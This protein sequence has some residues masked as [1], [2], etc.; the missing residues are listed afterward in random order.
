MSD[1]FRLAQPAPV[2]P[3]RP[4]IA[5]GISDFARIRREGKYYVDKTAQIAAL[6]EDDP[7]PLLLTRP[8]RFGKTL[9][10]DTLRRFLELDYKNP[11][12]AALPRQLFAGLRIME[13]PVLQSCRERCMAQYPVIAVTFAAVK[14]DSW[15]E[16]LQRMC[17]ALWEELSRHTAN[18]DFSVLP[19]H[20]QLR[21]QHHTALLIGNDRQLQ[22]EIIPDILSALAGW[23]HQVHG[24]PAYI[25]ID[26]YDTPLAKAWSA[27]LTSSRDQGR[28]G[29]YQRMAE[30]MRGILLPLLKPSP[31]AQDSIAGCIL[32]GCTR[33]SRESLFS[34]TNNL[35]VLGMD[36]LP[37]ADLM[38]FTEDEVGEML[39]CFSLEG[40]LAEARD[41]YD[42]Y[43]FAGV[44]IYNPWSIAHY[45]QDICRNPSHHPGNFW[46]AAGRND[47]LTAC[48]QALPEDG[49]EKLR[50]LCAGRKV[51]L[52]L[53][54]FFS[55]DELLHSQ[56]QQALFAL[57][58]HTGYITRDDDS[59]VPMWRIPNREVQECFEQQIL[60]MYESLA[61]GQA[62]G[63]LAAQL[64]SALLRGR[65]QEVQGLLERL[66]GRYLS[67]QAMALRSGALERLEQVLLSRCDARDLKDFR[68]LDD[69][70]PERVYQ[71]YVMGV[72]SGHAGG[73]LGEL[74]MERELGAGRADLS[75]ISA[76]GVSG[77]VLEFKK[78]ADIS[79]IRDAGGYELRLREACRRAAEAA[80]AQTERMGYA[81]GLLQLYPDM[82]E[83]QSYG[84]GCAG[85]RCAVEWRRRTPQDLQG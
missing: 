52:E 5:P 74:V 17:T 54:D 61:A 2:T 15:A 20:E 75:F 10:L 66:L 53:R 35:I 25:L 12:N 16:A 62:E 71:L 48:L 22:S 18:T 37:S 81:R 23:L 40:R 38:G 36:D 55:Y 4:G 77:C 43:R 79:P 7:G 84:I 57:L 44:R 28:A 32:S 82:Q 34:G 8:R 58:C 68:L 31:A 42:G 27:E 45:C 6:L 39:R 70:R 63:P 24:R 11:G 67:F 30:L 60:G 21:L 64:G 83:V 33:V 29:Y 46:A 72:L 41:W 50:Q 1:P 78:A 3:S 49:L 65:P 59:S 26:E 76:S 47:E 73:G 14:G 56:D 13:D 51:R 19:A 9:T 80:L 69:R 85:K